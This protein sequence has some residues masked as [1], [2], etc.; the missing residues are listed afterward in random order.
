VLDVLEEPVVAAPRRVVV[1]EPSVLTVLVV[2]RVVPFVLTRLL[3]V[4]E[5]GATRDEAD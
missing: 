2:V 5:A 1:D 4:V 3:V